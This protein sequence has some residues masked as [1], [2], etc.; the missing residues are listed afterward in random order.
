MKG[1][2]ETPRVTVVTG[3][4][5]EQQATVAPRQLLHPPIASEA[6]KAGAAAF[7]TPASNF[8]SAGF[9]SGVQR[10]SRQFC[11]MFFFCEM[12]GDVSA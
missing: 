7:L 5:A 2:S 6:K 4:L 3:A 11:P 8:W 10:G 1:R 9:K 12:N